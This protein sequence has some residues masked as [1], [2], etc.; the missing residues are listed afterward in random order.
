PFGRLK[1]SQVKDRPETASHY[2][3][4]HRGN[5][6]TRT[7]PDR[8]LTTYQYNAFNEPILTHDANGRESRPTYDALGRVDLLR[9][10]EVTP[11]STK[12]LSLTDYTYDVEPE[13]QDRELGRL[14]RVRREDYVSTT[15][16]GDEQRT[17]VDYDYDDALGRLAAVTHTVPSDV[18]PGVTA[19]YVVRYDYDA[20]DRIQTIHYPKLPGQNV[21]VKVGYHYT[22]APGNGQLRAIDVTEG[23]ATEPL[24]T[25][26]S[27]DEANRPLVTTTGDGI[28][29]LQL[30]DWRG[31]LAF[32]YLQTGANYACVACQRA[33]T[34]TAPAAG[35]C[36]RP[37]RRRGSPRTSAGCT[38]RAVA[39][40]PSST[41]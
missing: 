12:L 35:V 26:A 34:N 8:G 19:P 37:P 14:T 23:A 17:Q 20:F 32:Q 15:A 40:P 22:A 9:V 29:K 11:T 21:P 10:S 31:A 24:W 18:T 41:A 36:A 4:D 13:T 3:W 38:N 30:Y 5:L 25:L 1:S 39:A 27:T 2:T 16:E 7:D 28:G 6:L 33:Y